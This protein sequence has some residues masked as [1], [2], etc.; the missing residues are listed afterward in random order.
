[1]TPQQIA[2]IAELGKAMD[3]HANEVLRQWYPRLLGGPDQ[4]TD[5]STRRRRDIYWSAARSYL[6]SV[7]GSVD[8]AM[9]F[10]AE[11]D[12]YTDGIIESRAAAAENYSRYGD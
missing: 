11:Y 10:M 2:K 1:M 7:L 6:L 12:E 9:E 5:E 4:Y 3:D 8:K